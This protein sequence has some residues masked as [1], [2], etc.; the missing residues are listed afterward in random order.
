LE[1]INKMA[2]KK[3]TVEEIEMEV[4]KVEGF[5]DRVP[6]ELKADVA[7]RI[8]VEMA[9]W[10]ASSHFEGLGILEESKLAYRELGLK[11][12]NKAEESAS[13]Q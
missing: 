12:I 4:E 8:I 1:R 5:F 6:D 7:E 11:V 13:Q 10:G 2:D 9:I 3:L